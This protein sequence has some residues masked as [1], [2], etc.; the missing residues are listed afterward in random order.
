VTK[1]EAER[2]K[3]TGGEKREIRPGPNNFKGTCVPNLIP[4]EWGGRGTGP[5]SNTNNH[6]AGWTI[7]GIKWTSNGKKIN[8]KSPVGTN[9]RPQQRSHLGKD[10]CD[11]AFE[12]G[13]TKGRN[14]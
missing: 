3:T 11:G 13:E 2:K 4:P 7:R 1:R 9:Q 10:I 5:T 12:T 8:K 6:C 14:W